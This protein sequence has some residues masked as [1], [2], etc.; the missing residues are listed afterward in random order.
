MSEDRLL[1]SQV[2]RELGVSADHVRYLERCG[3]LRAERIGGVGGVRVFRRRDVE[4]LAEERAQR[5][6]ERTP[7]AAG[8][9]TRKRPVPST[10]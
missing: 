2:A 9:K 4:K 8:P 6:A 3:V 7:P 5:R 1:V 10:A